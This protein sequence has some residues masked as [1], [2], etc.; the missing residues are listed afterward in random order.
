MKTAKN[1][2][3]RD[4]KK[5]ISHHCQKNS[6]HWSW[7]F[8]KT[9]D[10]KSCTSAIGWSIPESHWRRRLG[11]LIFEFMEV[12]WD[13]CINWEFAYFE[14]QLL[15]RILGLENRQRVWK[16][17]SSVRGIFQNLE[18]EESPTR[19]SVFINETYPIYTGPIVPGLGYF[20]KHE[21]CAKPFPH[22]R[23]V[24]GDPPTDE[25]CECEKPLSWNLMWIGI[26]ICYL[27]FSI[28][29]PRKKKVI[30]LSGHLREK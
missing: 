5:I 9:I 15:K 25:R 24:R 12:P 16:A 6:A 2:Q 14:T 20:D 23:F 28:T 8:L 17:L 3:T 30:R 11:G 22:T 7:S 29:L 13:V 1:S 4:R 27:F 26:F 19:L 18:K 21:G 10:V